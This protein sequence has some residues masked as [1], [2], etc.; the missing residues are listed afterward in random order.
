[1]S[2]GKIWAKVVE[3][4]IVQLHDEDPSGHWHPD[5]LEFWQEVPDYCHI[6]WK[7]RDGEWISGSQAHDEFMAE[8]PIPQ[9]GPPTLMIHVVINED[10]PTKTVTALFNV[11]A[12]GI[13][14]G[15]SVTVG[16]KTFTDE[17]V[18]ELKYDQTDEPQI[19]PIRGVIT[20]EHNDDVIVETLADGSE[21]VIPEAYI[22][23]MERLLK[24][25]Q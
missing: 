6:G 13:Y 18:F 4:E 15:Y 19:I 12:A 21:V 25:N 2:E 24:G 7:F 10:R 23:P 22:L 17:E 8:R 14:T 5:F 3:N 11:T 9:P 16:D 20:S 1:M